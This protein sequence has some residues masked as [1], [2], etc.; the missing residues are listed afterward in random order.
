MKSGTMS[1]TQ[2]SQPVRG[3]QLLVEHMGDVFHR[4]SL[5]AIEVG[6]RW[7][8]GIPFLLLCRQQAGQ[9]L[10]AWPLNASGLDSIDTQNP[11]VAAVQ[12]SHGISYYEPHMFALLRW[13]FP[14]SAIAWI[15]ISGLGR[16]LLLSRMDSQVRFRPFTLM[17]MQ[18][19]W[20]ALFL[21]CVL[22]WLRSM[23]SVAAA[24]IDISGEP[25][26]IGYFIW[27]IFLS[28]G[29]FTV[30]ALTSWPFTIAPLL[31]LKEKRSVLSALAESLRLGKSF[32][33]KLT[34]INL[35]LG[36]VKLALIVLAMVFSAAPLPF[37]D[38]V[39]PA[40]LHDAMMVSL[41]FYLVANDFFQV[42]RINAFLAFREL[43]RGPPPDQLTS[44]A[45]PLPRPS[46][47]PH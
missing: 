42:V 15:V 46:N 3:T 38:E 13:L 22:G 28:L 2:A 31:A 8:F 5:L 1:E 47:T 4:P 39:G 37:S 29:F 26:L 19:A 17:A 7:L 14:A 6:W 21:A 9:I 23:Q 25:N 36:I 35:V 41:V 44:P 43:F 33:G 10:A 27:A 32:T 16:A 11:W 24:H 12:I 18:G 30:F 20:L 40:T 34:E 45:P